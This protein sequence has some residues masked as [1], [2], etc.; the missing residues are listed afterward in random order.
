MVGSTSPYGW[1]VVAQI[2]PPRA[3]PD[4]VNSESLGALSPRRN[5]HVCS[6]GPLNL[7]NSESKW[8]SGH[9][10]R[11]QCPPEWSC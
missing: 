3:T 8:A 2:S 1:V 6:P 4:T 5:T 9:W 11:N 7:A 10:I